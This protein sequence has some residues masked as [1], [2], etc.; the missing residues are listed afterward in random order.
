MDHKLQTAKAVFEYMK[1]IQKPKELKPKQLQ[2]FASLKW[3]P[4]VNEVQCDEASV[5]L[6]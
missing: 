5:C 1:S 2:E 6:V 4:G 3:S